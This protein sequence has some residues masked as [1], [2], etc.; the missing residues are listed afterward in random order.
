MQV[1]FNYLQINWKTKN[2]NPSF[3]PALKMRPKQEPLPKLQRGAPACCG[4]RADYRNWTSNEVGEVTE[5][6]PALLTWESQTPHHLPPHSNHGVPGIDKEKKFLETFLNLMFF[7]EGVVYISSSLL[8]IFTNID[9][10]PKKTCKFTPQ[11]CFELITRHLTFHL[12]L[13]RFSSF[14]RLP[15]PKTPPDP[16]SL[17]PSP[18]DKRSA[19]ESAHPTGKWWW[20]LFFD[21]TEVLE[22]RFETSRCLFL[23]PKEATKCKRKKVAEAFVN[24]FCV[25]LILNDLK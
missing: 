23:L 6:S 19:A 18:F 11:K 3:G 9:S 17:P 15:I 2:Q 14:I 4:W 24:C 22:D 7:D 5:G 25:E 8:R 13:R 20:W 21:V 16:P 1:H 10:C 12:H